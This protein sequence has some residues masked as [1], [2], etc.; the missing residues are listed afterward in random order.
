[1]AKVAYLKLW[2]GLYNKIGHYVFRPVLFAL[3]CSQI[4]WQLKP[5][6]FTLEQ[7]TEICEDFED[8]IDTEFTYRSQPPIKLVIDHVAITPYE[9]RDKEAFVES[10][11]ASGDPAA[12]LNEYNGDKYDVL[13]LAQNA[14]DPN[15]IVVM[16]IRQYI[17]QNNVGYNFPD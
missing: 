14:N 10:Y 15:D 12:A 7:A 6:Y 13:I 9:Q 16:D 11:V 2:S 3:V 5:L 8:L 4:S 17:E 1:M